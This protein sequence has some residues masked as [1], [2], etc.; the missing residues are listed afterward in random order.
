MLKFERISE[1][2]LIAIVG[3]VCMCYK[4]SLRKLIASNCIKFKCF[5]CEIQRQPLG[6]KEALELAE[7]ETYETN[8]NMNPGL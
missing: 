8:P 6:N 7:F 5:G 1:M 2:G 3:L 4:S